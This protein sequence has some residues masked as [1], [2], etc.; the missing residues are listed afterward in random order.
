MKTRETKQSIFEKIKKIVIN[1]LG[2]DEE[3]V[4]P[5]AKL[6][7]DLGADSL[8]LVELGTELEK[9][10]SIDILYEDARQFITV[11]DLWDEVCAGC[12]VT[13]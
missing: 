3:D 1:R 8:D 7:D 13:E 5:E 2:V 4:K 12:N 9:E 6:G 10:F 11:Q